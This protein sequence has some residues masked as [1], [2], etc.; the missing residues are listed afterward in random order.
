MPSPTAGR[1][2]HFPT[3]ALSLRTLFSGGED[4]R[5]RRRKVAHSGLEAIQDELATLGDDVASLGN[6][7]GEV[8]SDEAQATMRSIRERLDRIAGDAQS[9]TRAGVGAIEDRIEANPF[10]SIAVALG[11]GV[12]LATIMRR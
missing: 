1:R 5:Q 3:A 2:N 9:V 11:V 8:A 12:I 6:T 7:L 10:A 4:M